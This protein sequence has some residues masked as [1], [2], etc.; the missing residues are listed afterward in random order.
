MKKILKNYYFD[1]VIIGSMDTTIEK[2]KP[3][4][5]NKTDFVECAI[6]HYLYFLD[7]QNPSEYKDRLNKKMEALKKTEEYK[8]AGK[9]IR[10][11]LEICT[12][13]NL[14]D[15]MF[16]EIHNRVP[17]AHLYDRETGERID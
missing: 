13:K 14:K 2:F 12:E 17:A 16:P 10:A 8:K 7:R 4:F 1:Y 3:L 11:I 5:K 9:D 15:E 6:K